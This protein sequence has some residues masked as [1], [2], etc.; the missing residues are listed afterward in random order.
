MILPVADIDVALFNTGKF[1][2]KGRRLIST[3]SSDKVV[4][5]RRERLIIL[6]ARRAKKSRTYITGE[7]ELV[8]CSFNVNSC[9]LFQ[10]WKANIQT[11]SSDH[12]LKG[13]G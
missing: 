7:D 6:L 4:R 13:P 1:T 9:C 8:N 3:K 11:A 5:D 12:R 10:R 2:A